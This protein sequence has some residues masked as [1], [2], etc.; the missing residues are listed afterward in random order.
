MYKI[1]NHPDVP[2]LL[3]TPILVD[4]K[5]HIPRYW[6]S[7]YSLIF[8][9]NLSHATQ[10]RK[11]RYIDSFYNFV[12][13]KFGSGSLDLAIASTKLDKLSMYCESYFTFLL[14]NQADG[15]KS[16]NVRLKWQIVYDFIYKITLYISKGNHSLEKVQQLEL[17]FKLLNNLYQQLHIKNKRRS[18]PSI[19]SL[20]SNIIEY[21]YQLLDPESKLNP[22]RD[23]NTKWRVFTAFILL[24]H[25]GVRRGELLKLAVNVIN[26]S[27]NRYTGKEQYWINVQ[28]NDFDELDQRHN[29]PSIKTIAS[30]RQIPISQL[31]SNLVQEY[32]QNY[33]GK[34][35]HP[36]LFN[37]QKDNPWS[38][39]SLNE[40]FQR[41]YSVLPNTLKKELIDKN[42]KNSISPHDLRHTCAVIRLNQ[43]LSIGDSMDMALAKM[44]S[45]FG[46]SRN[47]SMPMRYAGVVFDHRLL[48]VW[49]S[50]F[51]DHTNILKSIPQ[52]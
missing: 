43:F 10:S 4:E 7:I 45:F 32:I 18:N 16:N 37:S 26:N 51:D 6:A 20:P 44:R 27:F 52:T 39:E 41:I 28:L 36:F 47:S 1:I 14:N 3:R 23:I 8:F 46:W 19:R 2:E 30:F 15:D 31:T 34:P 49:N 17:K 24:L 38:M 21:L 13:N 11:L 12:D 5:L 33:R 9:S 50:S 42:N 40:A 25:Q 35:N 29:K 22:F 48:N